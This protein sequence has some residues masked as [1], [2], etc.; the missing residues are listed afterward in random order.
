MTAAAVPASAADA[1]VPPDQSYQERLDNGQPIPLNRAEAGQHEESKTFLAAADADHLSEHDTDA[2]LSSGHWIAYPVGATQ[3]TVTQDPE[4]GTQTTVTKV[5]SSVAAEK[6]STETVPLAARTQSGYLSQA[7]Y[8]KAADGRNFAYF[9]M[10]E[11]FSYN[12][13]AITAYSQPV[14]NHKV[15]DWAAVLG[16]SFNGLDLSGSLGPSYY[17]WGGDGHGGLQTWRKADF[18][19]DQLHI[20]IGS[21][22]RYPW[23]HFYQHADGTEYS[24]TGM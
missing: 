7:Y 18:K 10:R 20:D 11:N 3:E 14:L 16:W 1:P 23:L 6:T 2:L 13:R 19:Y 24:T 15:Y 9:T 22:H 12:G 21:I 8:L 17:P 4:A 5:T